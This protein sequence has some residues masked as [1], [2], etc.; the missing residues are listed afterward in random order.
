M[1]GANGTFGILLLLL[2]LGL[3]L[4]SP[5]GAAVRV[6]Q[7]AGGAFLVYLAVD[8]FRAAGQEATARGPG[9]S[10]PPASRGVVAVILNPGAWIFLATTATA[11]VA[12]ATRDGGRGLAVLTSV[13]L[14]AGVM[15]ADGAVVAVG[16]GGRRGL[17]GRA[18]TWVVRILSL[19]LAALGLWLVARGILP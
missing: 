14:L 8:T 15:V 7:V 16:A 1:V 2:A 19:A 17:R 5:T 12:D 18:W 6:L 3:P 9:R 13:G 4:L 11:L 10:L